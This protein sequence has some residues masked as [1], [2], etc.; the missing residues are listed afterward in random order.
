MQITEIDYPLGTGEV[1]GVTRD[2]N[3]SLLDPEEVKEGIWV[4]V[5]AGFGVSVVDED[6]INEAKATIAEIESKT[7]NLYRTW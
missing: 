3:L 5:H 2:V 6:Y 4:L 7:D 1:D